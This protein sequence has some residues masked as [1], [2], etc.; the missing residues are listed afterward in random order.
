MIT[1]LFVFT[2]IY[3]A[4]FEKPTAIPAGDSFEIIYLEKAL[5]EEMT[6]MSSVQDNN[7]Q[8]ELEIGRAKDQNYLPN[9][10]LLLTVSSP[11]KRSVN[12]DCLALNL[13]GLHHFN[14]LSVH[15][16]VDIRLPDENIVIVDFPKNE[17][18]GSTKVSNLYALRDYE[19]GR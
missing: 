1:C 12:V 18:H 9:R 14:G 4:F 8:S 19:Q 3:F 15:E 16:A 7:E 17:W 5:S 11:S 10:W 13:A 6:D 2:A